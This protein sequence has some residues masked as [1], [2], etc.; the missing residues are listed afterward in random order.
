MLNLMELAGGMRAVFEMSFSELCR[1]S[2]S[3]Q[4]RHAAWRFVVLPI[5]ALPLAAGASG[6]VSLDLSGYQLSYEDTFKT[7][8]ISASGSCTA[9]IAHTPWNGDFGDAAFGNPGPGGPFSVNANGLAITARRLPNGKW[10]SGV[11]SSVDKDGPVHSGFAQ[12]YGYFEMKAILPSGM[13]TWPAFWL[14]GTDKSH[15]ASEIDVIEY[16]GGF[17][18]YFHTTEH[19]WVNGKNR[20][21][22]TL[23]TEVPEGSLSSGYNTYG[24]LITPRTTSF[25][26][27]RREFWSTPTPP[28][29]DQPM[30][31]L[32][33]LALGGGW[34][35]AGLRSPQVMQIAYIKVF[36]KLPPKN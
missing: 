34:P 3:F 10:V 33:N 36:Q 30:Y 31:I 23:M 11:I 27:N 28:E 4:L 19:V 8:D 15:A 9:W 25:Y 1:R 16:Y 29:Y 17:K 35:A 22:R 2:A 12:E 13:G 21:L 24:V 20:L 7:L 14:V 18:K 5:C 6:G 26:L 32:A